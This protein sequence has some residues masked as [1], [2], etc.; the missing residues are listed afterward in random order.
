MAMS[1][2]ERSRR[3]RAK[4]R[5]AGEGH[6][7]SCPLRPNDSLHLS[8]SME[9]TGLDKESV[10]REAL[11]L[12]DR[13]TAIY[14]NEYGNLDN[15]VTFRDALLNINIKKVTK[16][17][18]SNNS[19]E[20]DSAEDSYQKQINKE[21]R[22]LTPFSIE[23]LSP[24]KMKQRQTKARLKHDEQLDSEWGDEVNKLALEITESLLDT[25]YTKMPTFRG[26]KKMNPN[27]WKPSIRRM[28]VEDNRDPHET[29]KM[30]NWLKNYSDGNFLITLILGPAHLRKQ[31]DRVYGRYLGF[32]EK[33][34][35]YKKRDAERAAR[36]NKYVDQTA[37]DKA[38]TVEALQQKTDELLARMRAAEEE[39]ARRLGISGS[40]DQA[41]ASEQQPH[42]TLI[43]LNPTTAN[44]MAHLRVVPS[45]N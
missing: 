5:Y 30:L 43:A 10:T 37:S 41:E 22:M 15:F 23:D 3:Y 9:R 13:M 6:L 38:P 2:A 19:Q 33:Q 34:E 29:I 12:F 28:L 21:E 11:R 39:K 27:S 20:E 18:A 25:I 35:Y 44:I 26:G 8:N 4:K 36:R 1:D 7:L 24:K 45:S 16:G 17:T 31:Y 40:D 32:I 14:L 42:P